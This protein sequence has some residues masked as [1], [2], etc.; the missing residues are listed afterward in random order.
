M[1]LDELSLPI[2][3]NLIDGSPQENR[4]QLMGSIKLLSLEWMRPSRYFLRVTDKHPV[5]VLA[6]T[7]IIPGDLLLIETE[8]VWQEQPQLLEGKVVVVNLGSKGLKSLHLGRVGKQVKQGQNPYLS[9]D[10]FGDQEYGLKLPV[11]G[12]NRRGRSLAFTDGEKSKPG[13]LSLHQICGLV[14]MQVRL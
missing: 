3:E 13:V 11:R 4:S 9:V 8:P 2:V 7:H 5:A 10:V 12:E 6:K 14:M 1:K